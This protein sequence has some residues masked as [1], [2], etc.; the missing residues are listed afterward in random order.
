MFFGCMGLLEGF[1]LLLFS[2]IQPFWKF[3]ADTVW[4]IARIL[5]VISA[6]SYLVWLSICYFNKEENPQ[7]NI[8][9][10]NK[11]PVK[12]KVKRISLTIYAI[13]YIALSIIPVTN[14]IKITFL[15]YSKSNEYEYITTKEHGDCVVLIR[16]DTQY[17]MEAFDYDEATGH[18]TVY[19]GEYYVQDLSDVT[20]RKITFESEDIVNTIKPQDDKKE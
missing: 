13:S 17:V 9:S 1:I 6:F 16:N 5:I 18:L 14:T 10:F 11:A 7:A 15:P 8:L 2:N 19:A 20:I 3:N 4:L 12:E